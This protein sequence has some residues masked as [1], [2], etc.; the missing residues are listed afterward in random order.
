MEFYGEAHYAIGIDARRETKASRPY[1]LAHEQLRD[2]IL[3]G[4]LK[5]GSRLPASRDFAAHYKLSRGTVV[6]AF[7][8][9]HSEGLLSS[10]VGFG[11]WANR[12]PERARRSKGIVPVVVNLPSPLT[13]LSLSQPAPPFRSHVPAL[14][15]FP[16]DI[17]GRIASRCIRRAST[18]LL[19]QR[20]GR[21]HPVLR[22]AL[23]EYLGPS[24]GVSCDTDQ[25]VI[26][27]DVQQA[28]DILARVLLKPGD[29]GWME[30]PGYFGAVTA[31]HNSG[32]KLVPLPVDE[33]GISVEE[34]KRLAPRA[35]GVYV[36]PAHQF[37]LGS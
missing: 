11:T 21:G 26:V 14:N 35:K 33:Q 31:L 28:L 12:L 25:I 10:N 34:G 6:S 24:R 15:E 16:V 5:S 8:Q 19:V 30:D 36:T 1:T 18:G 27:S 37:P 22:K 9:L 20:D 29:L 32:A 2:A 3:D 23:A 17:W 7:E 13:G 4:R